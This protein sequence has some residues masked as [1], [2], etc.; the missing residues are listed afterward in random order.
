MSKQTLEHLASYGASAT[1]A[2]ITLHLCFSVA[3]EEAGEFVRENDVFPP[4]SANDSLYFTMTYMY[5][6]DGPA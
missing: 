5:Y 6:E 3:L 4:E 1:E 2:A